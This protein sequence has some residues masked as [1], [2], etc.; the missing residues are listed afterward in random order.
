MRDGSQ[1][2]DGGWSGRLARRFLALNDPYATSEGAP[3]RAAGAYLR[4]LLAPLRRVLVASL[5]ATTLLAA[6]EVWLIAYT[7]RL[8]DLLDDAGP[9][10]IWSAHGGE[11]LL[12][13]FVVL[14]IRP[15]LQYLRT[16]INDIGLDCNAATLVRMLA[17]A[18]VSRQSVG[19]FQEDL[20]G[21]IASRLVDIGNHAGETLY[22]VINA[23]AY[24]LVYAVGIVLLMAGTDPRLAAPLL[25]W[26]AL[27]IVLV[28]LAV[29]RLSRAQ[30]HFQRAKAGLVGSVVDTCSN[31]E[32]LKLFST[33]AQVE[34]GLRGDVERVR[35]RLFATRRLQLSVQTLL[36][37]LEGL[38]LVGFVG[39][40]IVLHADGAA[41]LGVIGAAI[42]LCLRITTMA[43]WILRAVWVIF[44][45]IGS[46]DDALGT[47]AQPL[48]IADVADAPDL[49]VTAGRIDV[50]ALH[51]RYGHGV[52]GLAGVDLTVHAG[53][54]IG[55]VGRS[56]AGKSTLVNLLLRFHEAESGRITI[57][58][59]DIRSVS[60]DSLRAAIGLVGQQASLLHRSVRDNIALGDESVEQAAVEAAARQARAHEFIVDLVDV[61]G[62]CGYDAFVGERGVKLS[63]GQRQR[64]ALARVILKGAPILVLDEATSALDSEVEAD[65]QRSLESV[66][67][68]R[69]VIAIAHRLSTIASMDRILVMDTGRIVEQGTHAQ[70]L[71]LG[72]AYAG[73]W[74]RQSGGFIGID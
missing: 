56:G 62:R 2:V 35:Q 71:A 43:E 52:G 45:R 65:I 60:Q 37:T 39:Y 29:P 23:L 27:Y 51:H 44:Q 58:D 32:T 14:A 38:V 54:K 11:L 8:I 17:H 72:G 64:I 48:R 40:G 74:H 12:A 25:L 26:L 18:H 34:D 68:D 9:A 70:L 19:W 49:V 57:D 46:L 15:A 5:I 53:E 28:S 21:R 61:D 16:G 6:S 4:A 3:P 66:M 69:T 24:G 36:T 59:Q 31:V 63:G 41:S 73:F 20:S 1:N 55:L 7:G 13:A 10:G 67:E 30:R 50:R 33:P 42:A 22:Q 47:V